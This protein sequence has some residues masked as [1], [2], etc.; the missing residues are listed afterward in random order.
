MPEYERKLIDYLPFLIA[1][2][3]EFQTI[4]GT[5]DEEMRKA[6][7]AVSF[8][9]NEGF[10]V[11]A[12]SLGL[13]RMEAICELSGEG[14]TVEE[15]RKNI[16]AKLL[17]DRPYTMSTIYSR[18][19]VLC[20]ENFIMR[21]GDTPYSLLVRIDVSRRVFLNEIRKMLLRCTPAN[22]GLLGGLMSMSEGGIYSGSAIY[23]KT[24]IV[25]GEADG[26]IETSVDWSE[27][28]DKPEFFDPDEHTHTEFMTAEEKK[29]LNSIEFASTDEVEELITELFGGDD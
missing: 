16:I 10:V 14:L 1:E 6:W 8:V 24:K 17:G 5:E 22:I 26:E 27:I 29:K 15:R 21:Y 23:I 2:T 12:E 25:I 9:R 19:K 13:S 18:L 3:R 11:S 20:D 4:T 28:Y 7:E